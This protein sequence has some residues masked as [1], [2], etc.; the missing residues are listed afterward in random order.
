MPNTC[1]AKTK[2]GEACSRKTYRF[3]YC[4]QHWG[5]KILK[6]AVVPPVFIIGLYI[7]DFYPGVKEIYNDVQEF[8]SEKP[9]LTLSK[10][11]G[12]LRG[13][14]LENSIYNNSDP[15]IHVFFSSNEI[16]IQSN[17]LIGKE[18]CVGFISLI[19][20]PS[21]PIKLEIEPVTNKLILSMT[22]YDYDGNLVTDIKGNRLG[23][24]KN[25]FLTWNEDKYGVEIIDNEGD[26]M[27]SINYDGKNNLYI[28][29]VFRN[30]DKSFTVFDDCNTSVGLRTRKSIKI[31]QKNITNIFHYL[32]E[33]YY[34]KRVLSD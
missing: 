18:Q 27:V 17:Q 6:F 11:D 9:N 33:D 19:G 26:V 10:E 31:N 3:W 28:R 13:I 34:G 22:I 7:A 12:N 21:C 30:T 15:N 1:R 24:Y 23:A 29:G 16:E 8:T 25:K 2:N 5:M 4:K 32:G 20:T 14:I